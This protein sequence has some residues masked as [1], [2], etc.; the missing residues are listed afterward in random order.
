M[1]RT[2]ATFKLIVL[3]LIVAI[4]A[5]LSLYFALLD[6]Q[7]LA[8]GALAASIALLVVAVAAIAAGFFVIR[9]LPPRK[10]ADRELGWL[11]ALAAGAFLVWTVFEV[12]IV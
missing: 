11:L 5:P 12:T 4:A 6:A 2:S 7:T 3:S 1:A 8:P 9:R 10:N